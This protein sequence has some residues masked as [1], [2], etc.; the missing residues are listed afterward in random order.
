MRSVR[1]GAGLLSVVLMVMIAGCGSGGTATQPLPPQPRPDRAWT[2][3]LNEVRPDGTVS[4]QTALRAFAVAFGPLPGISAPAGDR[5][6]VVSG[7]AALR[8]LVGHW[9]DISAEQQAAA[10]RLVPE[11]A[12]L[13]PVAAVTP[14]QAVIGAAWREGP[15]PRRSDTFYTTLAQQLA[16][17]LGTKIGRPLGIPV[18]AKFGPMADAAAGAA[19]GVYTASGGTS[20]NP[21]KCVVTVGPVGDRWD[22]DQLSHMMAH[23]VWHCFEGAIGGLAFY[24]HGPSWV[25]EGQAAWV[26]ESLYPQGPYSAD[27]WWH[28]LT[29]PQQQLFGRT[30]DALGF[31]AQLSSSGVDVWSA[32]ASMLGKANAAAFTAA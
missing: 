25:I 6:T 2:A 22:G 27:W 26:G 3:V 30:Y 31:Y 19:T 8:W 13:Q 1:H 10:G 5:G 18:T 23:E 11:L 28:Y 17:Q 20:G 14:Q 21:G 9:A 7:S 4:T 16:T 32:L 12:G 24:Y 29:K 15:A